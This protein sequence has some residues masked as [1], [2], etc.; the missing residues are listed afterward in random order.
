MR[1]IRTVSSSFEQFLA[2][3][4][5][6]GGLPPSRTPRK[7]PRAQTPGGNERTR[8]RA[9]VHVCAHARAGKRVR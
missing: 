4:L 6:G 7:A 9:R 5:P 1:S 3:P 2:P 8:A